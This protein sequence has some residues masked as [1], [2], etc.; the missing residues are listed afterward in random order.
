MVLKKDKSRT[1][2][3]VFP[4]EELII[5]THKLQEKYSYFQDK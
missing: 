5:G 4:K 1:P 2:Y 3:V